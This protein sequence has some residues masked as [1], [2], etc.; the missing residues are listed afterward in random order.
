LPG[1]APFLVPGSL[2]GV[3]AAK[4][5]AISANAPIHLFIGYSSLLL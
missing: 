5:T 1:A 3:H 2:S 4:I